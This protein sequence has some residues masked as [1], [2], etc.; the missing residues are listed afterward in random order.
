MFGFFRK[1]QPPRNPTPP[2]LKWLIIFFIGYA[3][4]SHSLRGPENPVRQ[5]TEQAVQDLDPSTII[6]DYKSK[7]IPENTSRR[8][9]DTAAGKGNPALCGQEVALAYE[10]KDA[11][12]KIQ[13]SASKTQPYRFR[14]GEPGAMPAIERNAVGLLPGGKRTVWIGPNE[15]QLRY[16]IELLSITPALPPLDSIPF[17]MFDTLPGNGK[18]ITCG[19]QATINLMVWNTEGKKLY[20]TPTP[21]TFITGKSETFIGLEQGVLGMRTGGQRTL[22]V[23][24]VFQKTLQGNAPVSA[25]P[26]PKNQTVIVDI[27]AVK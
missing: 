5:A 3:M 17:R 2:W 25:V 12:N 26:F 9:K 18:P 22:I 14:I 23:P 19:N 8:V 1:K 27:E 4:F 10:A 16:D 7:I 11:A 15:S 13:N 24:P 21:L 6:D 20:E